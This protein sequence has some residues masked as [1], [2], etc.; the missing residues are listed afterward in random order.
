MIKTEEKTEIQVRERNVIEFEKESVYIFNISIHSG[1]KSFGIKWEHLGLSNK[2]VKALKENKA[3]PTRV[4]FFHSLQN[5]VNQLV[6]S[7]KKIQSKLM[8]YSEPYWFVTESN[9]GALAEEVEIMKDNWQQFKE[10]IMEEYEG[11]KE[12]YLSAVKEIIETIKTDDNVEEIEV[13]KQDYLERFPT[14]DEINSNFYLE[15]FGPIKIP[16]IKE[17]CL[18]DAELAEYQQR[19]HK[20]KAM[21]ELETEFKKGLQQKLGEA[22]KTASDEF[23]HILAENLSTLEELEEQGLSDHKKGKLIEA[24]ERAKN[25][26]SFEK[27]LEDVAEQFS[28]IA[29]CAN[30][31]QFLLMEESIEKLREKLS[32]EKDLISVSTKGHRAL[33]QWLR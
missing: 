24:V 14:F 11:E 5:K 15:M 28:Q 12:K 3:Q 22:I 7:K 2:T 26:V 18:I 6:Y 33:A 20:A 8:V 21:L 4:K 25:L 10:Q 32:K 16:S 30:S 1:N 17:Q 19:N 9:F 29:E 27:G 23:C 31:K 13:I